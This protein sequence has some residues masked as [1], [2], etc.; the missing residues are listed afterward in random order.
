[1][2]PPLFNQST[3]ASPLSPQRATKEEEDEEEEE[4]DD[5]L[6]KRQRNPINHQHLHRQHHPRGTRIQQRRPQKAHRTPIIHGRARD[7]ERETRHGLIHQDAEIIAQIRAR[8]AERPGTGQHENVAHQDE[9]VGDV[10]D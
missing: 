7:I 6:L 3:P 4:V 1:M 5:L 8:D 9:R 10:G 2:I